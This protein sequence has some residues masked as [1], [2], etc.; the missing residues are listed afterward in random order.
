MTV[1]RA[2]GEGLSAAVK[3]QLAAREPAERLALG[4]GEPPYLE[5]VI[6]AGAHAVFLR[7]AAGAIDLGRDAAGVRRAR[8]GHDPLHGAALARLSISSNKLQ[9]AAAVL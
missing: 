9:W 1:L 8:F 2:H 4:V 7:F 5:Y 6:G 3:E